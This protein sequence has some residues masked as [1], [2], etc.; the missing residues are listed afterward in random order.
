[1]RF[2]EVMGHYPTGVTVVTGTA[3]G[4]TLIGMVV[5]VPVFAV[6][7]LLVVGGWAVG[8][9]HPTAGLVMMWVPATLIV[10]A[11]VVLAVASA[12]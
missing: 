6:A 1:M 12:I 9:L 11:S 2:R 3:G 5:G 4:G 8:R 7:M 10:L